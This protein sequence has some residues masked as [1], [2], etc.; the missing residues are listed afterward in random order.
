M[1]TQLCFC[2]EAAPRASRCPLNIS[3][4]A[5]PNGPESHTAASLWG[6]LGIHTS[7]PPYC[8]EDNSSN[9]RGKEN[10]PQSVKIPTSK[11]SA[12]CPNRGVTRHPRLPARH[13]P[14]GQQKGVERGRIMRHSS[15]LRV[16]RPGP[17]Q[18]VPQRALC[19]EP[20]V[21]RG[22]RGVAFVPGSPPSR[23]LG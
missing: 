17:A 16:D 19:H 14:P 5:G 21:S 12:T 4:Q 7:G 6:D 23:S 11:D 22:S 1:R 15:L 2:G 10:D 8:E 9:R 20:S 3:E 18:A 13:R